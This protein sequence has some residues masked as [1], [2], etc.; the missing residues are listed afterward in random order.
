VEGG[1]EGGALSTDGGVDCVDPVPLSGA[2]LVCAVG[3]GAGVRSAG[4]A[5]VV[6]SLGV[7]PP[8]ETSTLIASP[9]SV[10]AD[11]SSRVARPRAYDAPQASRA[12]ATARPRTLPLTGSPGA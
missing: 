3:A 12:I 4:T 1:V 10:A 11:A 2:G 7:A 5:A 6:L 9:V 8:P